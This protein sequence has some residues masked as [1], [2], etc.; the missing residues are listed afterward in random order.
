MIMS[1]ATEESIAK[2]KRR[3]VRRVGRT[4]SRSRAKKSFIAKGGA[5][6]SWFYYFLANLSRSFGIRQPLVPAEATA[7]YY[8]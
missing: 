2:S 1:A 4:R 6:L 3:S 5:Y 8:K 7:D